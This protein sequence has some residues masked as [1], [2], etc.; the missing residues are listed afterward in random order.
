MYSQ[1]HRII[2]I[3]GSA[4]GHEAVIAILK[5]FDSGLPASLFLVL[6]SGTSP[7]DA[8][9]KK[10]TKMGYR[11][12]VAEHG[13][14]VEPRH[15][16]IAPPDHHLLINEDKVWITRGLRVNRSRPAIDLLFRSAAV[17]YGSRH[18][19]VLVSGY[20]YDGTA[21]LQAVKAAGGVTVVQ[22]PADALYPE[23]PSHALDN[24]DIDYSEP[25]GSI[26]E[27]LNRLITTPAGPAVTIP[28]RIKLENRMDLHND[29]NIENM[30]RLGLQR[31][32]T[33]PDCGGPLWEMNQD[34]KGL[35]RFRC[36]NGHS[37]D[38][39][40]LMDGKENEVEKIMWIALRTLEEKAHIQQK[41]EKRA[42][43]RNSYRS[44]E[45]RAYAERLREFLME[46][47]GVR[48]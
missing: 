15:L 19:G 40:S 17:A 7:P 27:L 20:L 47:Y 48:K 28:D 32:V 12:V 16:Y 44:T 21:G 35:P 8:L 4:G 43:G 45:T 37:M 42:D 5:S 29:E 14:S 1:N 23:M 2:S 36:H 6:H 34:E 38:A 10:L 39:A 46:R 11:A 33:C 31:P 41:I 3:G 22:K 25:A 18:I 13:A 30:N 26:G 24:A 9:Q